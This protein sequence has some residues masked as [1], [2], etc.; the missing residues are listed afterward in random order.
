[1]IWFHGTHCKNVDSIRNRG[2]LHTMPPV[3]P[4]TLEPEACD[5][6]SRG[7]E[8]GVF[9]TDDW[10][11]A[12]HYSYEASKDAPY[13]SLLRKLEGNRDN[14][15]V[16]EIELPENIRLLSDGCGGYMTDGEDISPEFIK[17]IDYYYWDL[18]KYKVGDAFLDYWEGE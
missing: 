8:R 2:L 1:M 12:W 4:E 11:S 10:E 3:H 18:Q 9:L 5:I 7:A 15:C 13:P 17:A 16:I 6:T 14:M